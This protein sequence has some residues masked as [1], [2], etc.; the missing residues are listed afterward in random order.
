MFL[1]AGETTRYAFER[2]GWPYVECEVTSFRE[3]QYLQDQTDVFNI[4]K[5]ITQLNG[6]LDQRNWQQDQG[7]GLPNKVQSEASRL[8][9][10]SAFWDLAHSDLPWQLTQSIR[11]DFD[12]MNTLEAP[13]FERQILSR[14]GAY[15]EAILVRDSFQS[16]HR[17]EGR[18]RVL[19]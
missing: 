10:G 17:D 6:L 9:A 15:A 3:R 16:F 13:D 2:D 7:T 8:G 1:N 19:S 5:K 11:S 12:V 14:H 4:F 18:I